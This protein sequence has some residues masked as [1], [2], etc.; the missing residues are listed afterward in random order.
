MVLILLQREGL[1]IAFGSCPKYNFIISKEQEDKSYYNSY[2]Q[3][4]PV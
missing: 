2:Y 4:A 1:S 3:F